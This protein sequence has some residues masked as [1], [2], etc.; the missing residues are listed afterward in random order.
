MLLSKIL[1]SAAVVFTAA[2][3]ILYYFYDVMLK[4]IVDNYLTEVFRKSGYEA[5]EKAGRTVYKS[6][7]YSGFNGMMK[8]MCA[9]FSK[10]KNDTQ[11]IYAVFRNAMD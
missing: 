8:E 10:H 11:Y 5:D 6:P 1:G 2:C 9:L 3:G 4:S 7:D